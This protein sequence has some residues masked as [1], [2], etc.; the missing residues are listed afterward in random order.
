MLKVKTSKKQKGCQHPVD[1]QY[2]WISDDA[3]GRQVNVGCC[4]C[5]KILGTKELKTTRR[6]R[7]ACC[8]S[9]TV[10]RHSDGPVPNTGGKR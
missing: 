5:G 7:R 9:H 8:A 2:S 4:K 10:G 6:L 1:R 3:L